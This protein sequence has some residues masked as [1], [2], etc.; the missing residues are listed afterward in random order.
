M[1][2]P[3]VQADLGRVRMKLSFLAGLGAGYVLGTR[4]GRARYD[5]IAGKAREVWSDPRVQ[6]K[7][8]QAKRMVNRSSG[9]GT[10]SGPAVPPSP[11]PPSQP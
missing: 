3:R 8:D 11:T 4:S 7:A 10:G 1:E 6:E 9:T 5:Q 2:G